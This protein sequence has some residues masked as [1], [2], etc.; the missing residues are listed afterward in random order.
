VHIKVTVTPGAKKEHVKEIS[1][2]IFTL[3]V[4]VKAERNMANQRVRE[5][6]AEHFSVP[7][8]KIR[9]IRGHRSNKKLISIEK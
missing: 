8:K 4:K 2:G 6:L 1:P 3:S 7:V 9:M 5:L